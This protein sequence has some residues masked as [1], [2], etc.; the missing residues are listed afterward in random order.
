MIVAFA[1]ALFLVPLSSVYGQDDKLH[2]RTEMS[3]NQ[4]TY[5]V[6]LQDGDSLRIDIDEAGQIGL[7]A[8]DGVVSNLSVP[9]GTISWNSFLR[10]YL[11]TFSCTD[12]VQVEDEDW[13]TVT[14]R[15][16]AQQ[17]MVVFVPEEWP[18]DIE[19]D[20]ILDYGYLESTGIITWE[21]LNDSFLVISVTDGW[22]DTTG[23]EFVLSSTGYGDEEG[24]VCT[25]DRPCLRIFKVMGDT[26]LSLRPRDP[27]LGDPVPSNFFFGIYEIPARG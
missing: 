20:F 19:T 3:S 9:D 27:W 16:G 1:L 11:S 12:Y 15:L 21:N 17:V 23:I 7:C 8:V 5:Y 24:I 13:F 14:P 18:D 4:L 26:S 22:R 2:Y 10:E 25:S 6:E